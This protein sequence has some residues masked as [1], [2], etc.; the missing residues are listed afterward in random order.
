MISK[1]TILK[2]LQRFAWGFL[3]GAG[4]SFVM[5]T[6]NFTNW[7]DVKEW[8]P[9]VFFSILTGGIMGLQKAIS[10]YLKYDR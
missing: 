9:L 4:A 2:A 8:L 7:T 6:P 1:E 5:A 10:G 3:A